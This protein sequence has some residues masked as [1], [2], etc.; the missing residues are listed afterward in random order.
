MKISLEIFESVKCW[1]KD[2]AYH[3][4]GDHPAVIHDDGS[5]EY[6]LDGQLVKIMRSNGSFL[7]TEEIDRR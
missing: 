6:H 2:G 3:R 5:K 4:E 1:Y 7:Y